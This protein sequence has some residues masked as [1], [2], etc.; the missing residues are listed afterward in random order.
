MKGYSKCPEWL[1][2]AY[3]RAVFFTCQRCNQHEEKVGK[4]EIH[5]IKAGYKGGLYT[6]NNVKILC[7]ECHKLFNEDW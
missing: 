7:K 1:K 6:P 2:L 4:L 5:R 3:R